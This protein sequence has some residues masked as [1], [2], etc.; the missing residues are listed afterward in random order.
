VQI[1]R[2]LLILVIAGCGT[3]ALASALSPTQPV[4]LRGII[5]L[6]EF[7]DVKHGVTRSHVS[8]RFSRDLRAYIEEMSY[9]RVALVG[10]VSRKW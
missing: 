8:N 5:I 4:V 2:I 7:P 1:R 10:E 6:V 3:A 9:G